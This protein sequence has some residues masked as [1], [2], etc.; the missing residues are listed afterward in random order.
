VQ[1]D[2]K[3]IIVFSVGYAPDK[4]GKMAMLFG[5]L[6]AAGGENRLNV[7]VTR[8]REKIVMFTSIWPEQLSTTDSKNRGPKLLQQYLEFARNV[9]QRNFYKQR[10]RT[11]GG[12]QEATLS[13]R[14]RKWGENRVNEFVFEEQRVPYAD[15]TIV[16]DN[17]HLGVVLTDDDR[18][19][20][21]ISI[22]DAFAYTPALL[23]KKHWNFRYVYSRQLW[24]DIQQLENK[25]L[26]FLGNQS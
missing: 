22:K 20:K 4:N 13:T 11:Y 14:I 6:S 24:K 17:R 5:S 26:L 2:E 21:S 3:D 1:G 19:S 23:K 10:E 7:A 16:K 12:L 9:S 15:I 18:F 25:L 8:A